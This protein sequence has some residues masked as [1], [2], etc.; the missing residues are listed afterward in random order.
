MSAFVPLFRLLSPS[1]RRA[2]LSTL[3]FH[4]VLPEPDPLFPALPDAA[5]FREILGW[6]RSWFNVL[7]LSEAV[8]RLATGTLHDR[9]AAITFD[10]GYADNFT[11]ALPLLREC[12]LTAT[13]FI[14]TGFLDG[15]CMFN[16]RIIEAIRG[17]PLENLDLD[18]LGLGRHVLLTPRDR[19]TVIETLI[20]R[21]KYLPA[22]E[23]LAI[24]E[25]VAT[26]AGVKRTPDLMMSS[27]Q[28]RELRR[29]G[30]QIGAHTVSHPILTKLI[31]NDARREI[32]ESKSRLEG[33]LDERVDLFAYPNGK[34]GDDYGDEHA[35]MARALG[36]DA[37]FSTQRGA[38]AEN[39]DFM[40]LPRF[41]PWGRERVRFGARLA[42]N[43]IRSP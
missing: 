36:F 18:S 34:P 38:A 19:R 40:Q 9:A 16:D 25:R 22:P 31:P 8:G 39:S 42:A 32:A 37:A 33:L 12:G 17:C 27:R 4:R 24:S 11:V 1:G 7:P 21:I 15:A 35:A 29:A 3:I 2:R 10:D 20:D 6:L 28:V 5:R 43:L 14:A 26:M 30:M 13:F 41:T 23:R